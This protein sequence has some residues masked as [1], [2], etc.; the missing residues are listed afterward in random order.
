MAD[1]RLPLLTKFIQTY[2]PGSTQKLLTSIV[3]LNNGTIKP[4]Q[5][6]TITGL[7]WQN[8][9]TWGGY[10]VFRVTMY[11]EP[12]NLIQA[13]TMSDNIFFAQLAVEMG[14]EAYIEGLTALG[15]GEEIPCEYPV[16]EAQISNS[17]RLY[18]EVLLADTAY[19]QGEILISPIQLAAIYSGI[20]NGG[21]IMRPT[22]LLSG[23][24]S[25]EVWKAQVVSEANVSVL[26]QA[27]RNV[28]ADTHQATVDRPFAKLAGK[29]GTVQKGIEDPSEKL[30]GWFVGYDQNNPT[31]VLAIQVN[32][33]Q[34]KE[35]SSYP[36]RKFGEAYDLLYKGGPYKVPAAA[37]R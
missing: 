11:E 32:D 31:M 12:M 36:H 6:R 28:V 15:I 10:Q 33:T 16:N 20:A 37:V 9:S 35:V 34:D 1:E 27:L 26:A 13:F 22:I 4:E 5:T 18:E 14:A 23:E 19:G 17:G 24:A 25:P 7:S 8:D 3:A 2:S 29:S 30:A 21:N